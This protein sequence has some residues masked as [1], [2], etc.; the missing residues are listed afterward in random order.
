M[1]ASKDNESR[2]CCHSPRK[3]SCIDYRRTPGTSFADTLPQK[4]LT[5]SVQGLVG[6]GPLVP[7]GSLPP[8]KSLTNGNAEEK[9]PNPANRLGQAP[10]LPSAGW[11]RLMARMA[12][13]YFRKS[14]AARRINS[15]SSSKRANS[16]ACFPLR[17]WWWVCFPSAR[18][19]PTSGRPT[20]WKLARQLIRGRFS[21]LTRQA[22]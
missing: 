13:N 9:H 21:V 2:I 22:S 8:S 14:F 20:T 10:C 7:Q 5:P 15:F 16:T 11:M 1:S 12:I 19:W 17:A 4:R 3:A 18:L 6:P